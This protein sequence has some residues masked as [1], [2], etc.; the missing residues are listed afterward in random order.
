[1]AFKRTNFN[2]LSAQKREYFASKYRFSKVINFGI[3]SDA[4]IIPLGLET[5]YYETPAHR[6]GVQ[7]VNGQKIGLNGSSFD[8]Y[9]KCNGRDEQGNPI[10]SLCCQLAQKYKEKYPNSEDSAKRII[11]A[12]S[13]RIQLPVLILG[14]SLAEQ[15]ASYPISKV[16]ILNDLKSE[17]GLKFAYID[18]SS[19]SFSQDIVKAYGKKLKEEGIL[20][21]DSDENSEEY[22]NDIRERLTKTVIKVHGYEKK[23]FSAAMKEYSFFPFSNQAIAAQSPEGEREAIIG[24][25]N[26]KQIMEKVNE[27]L[28]LFDVEVD[29]IIPSCDDKTLLEYFN[30]AMGLDIKTGAPKETKAEEPVEEK[31]EVIEEAPKP[32]K[33]EDL[34]QDEEYLD[35]M[36]Q[37]L[38]D[39]TEEEPET[40]EV[41]F[42]F[43]EEEGDF[44]G[45]EG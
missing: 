37:N 19:Y 14:N 24:Y 2:R 15:K 29:N 18:M 25:K 7:K 23:G 4:Y 36:L 42:Q 22:L 8:C 31:I 1:M 28:T 30:S 43:N 39:E 12:C 3:G 11:G 5:G 34:K 20:D 21:Y 38:D 16:S 26:N 10:E 17:A 44:F 9:I 35:N 6:V 40:D 45:E 32:V 27:F 13:D 33:V 41:D